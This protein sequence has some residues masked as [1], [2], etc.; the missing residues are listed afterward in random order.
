MYITCQIPD[1]YFFLLYIHLCHVRNDIIVTST[2]WF[3][4]LSHVDRC[5]HLGP[6]LSLEAVQRMDTS[7]IQK[8]SLSKDRNDL[9]Q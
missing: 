4:M 3:D 2:L 7:G 6:H 8:R 9:E 1:I 5:I